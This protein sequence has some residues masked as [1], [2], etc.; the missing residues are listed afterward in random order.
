LL[1]VF[2]RTNPFR[3]CPQYHNGALVQLPV[4]TDSTS[5][6]IKYAEQGVEQIFREGFEYHKVGVML[7]GFFPIDRSQIQ[8]FEPEDRVRMAIVSETMDKINKQMGTNTLYFAAEGNRRTWSMKR[9]RKSP[10][11]T[12]DWDDIPKVK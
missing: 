5:E 4:P 7:A 3:D 9:E 2:L 6:L 12:T 10:H 8:L 1:T 11:Y